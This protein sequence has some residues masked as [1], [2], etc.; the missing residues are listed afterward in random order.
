MNLFRYVYNI[1]ETET[2][3]FEKAILYQHISKIN[4]I[5]NRKKK[6]LHLTTKKQFIFA[7]KAKEYFHRQFIHWKEILHF[8]MTLVL[9]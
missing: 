4:K 3:L 7:D 1:S 6:S 5:Q 9:G 2:F 8:H